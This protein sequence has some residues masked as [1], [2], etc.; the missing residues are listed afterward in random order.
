MNSSTERPVRRLQQCVE[1]Y[2]AYSWK[3]KLALVLPDAF[4]AERASHRGDLTV[5]L[6]VFAS[7]A[8]Q[9]NL[10]VVSNSPDAARLF[11]EVRP[12]SHEAIAACSA[13]MVL[14]SRQLNE[15]VAAIRPSRYV[16]A[17]PCAFRI[18]HKRVAFTAGGV[19]LP[20]TPATDCEI[21]GCLRQ[22]IG[23]VGRRRGDAVVSRGTGPA[24]A[25]SVC[26]SA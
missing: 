21:A 6:E 10:A 13:A 25:P 2:A 11:G 3:P 16:A 7:V 18:N 8:D 24:S 22:P 9:Y 12:F 1:R 4:S 5:A 14:L 17:D 20:F 19:E 15:E 23:A 26:H